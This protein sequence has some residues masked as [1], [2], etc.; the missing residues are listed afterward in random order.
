M[1]STEGKSLCSSDG[2]PT[3]GGAHKAEGHPAISSQQR[4]PTGSRRQLCLPHPKHMAGRKKSFNEGTQTHK[5]NA[6]LTARCVRYQKRARYDCLSL[7]KDSQRT[8]RARVLL[9]PDGP[10]LKYSAEAVEQ[11]PRR[12]HGGTLNAPLPSPATP[13][14]PAC[15]RRAKQ[16]RQE[17]RRRGRVAV[18]E[19]MHFK[20]GATSSLDLA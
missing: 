10:H 1:D 15:I 11:Q 4:E 6:A 18:T 20:F 3:N 19:Q 7:S 13:R 9:E 2:R 8:V 5:K 12:C 17:R 16:K 14:C